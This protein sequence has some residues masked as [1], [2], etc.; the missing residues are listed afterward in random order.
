MGDYESR[1]DFTGFDTSK[2]RYGDR[3]LPALA[4]IKARSEAFAVG[5]TRGEKAAYNLRPIRSGAWWGFWCFGRG[6]RHE[7]GE[8]DHASV[9]RSRIAPTP[10]ARQTGRPAGSPRKSIVP[11]QRSYDAPQSYHCVIESRIEVGRCA[12]D[13]LAEN[14]TRLHDGIVPSRCWRR[15]AAISASVLSTVSANPASRI[16]VMSETTSNSAPN[17]KSPNPQPTTFS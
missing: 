7:T 9:R 1:V 3:D 15:I 17:T 10:K 5:A 8:R 14:S 11:P 12:D 13:E 2:I 6:Q 4:K 16:F